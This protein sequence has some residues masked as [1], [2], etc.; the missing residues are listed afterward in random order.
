V[1]NSAGEIFSG[2]FIR[3]DIVKSRVENAL[4]VPLYSVISRNDI[5]Y[6]FIEQ[7]GV[8]RR[9]EV[10]LGILEGWMIQITEGLEPGDNLI[11]EGHRD[12]DEGQPVNV[13]KSFASAEELKK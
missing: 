2:M 4:A 10:K 6:V 1:A 7:D 9:R 12:V 5:Q 8:A 3:A 13:V 11:I